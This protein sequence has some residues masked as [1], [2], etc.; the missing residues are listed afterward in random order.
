MGRQATWTEP[1][2]LGAAMGVFRRK[3]FAQTTVRDLQEATGLHPGSLYKAYGSKDRLFAAAMRAYNEQVVEARI[4]R[5]LLREDDP[6]AGIRSFFTSTFEKR[7][8]PD[9]GCL[10]TNTAIEGFGLD[11]GARDEVSTG[12]D[13]IERGLT[14][15]LR[16]AQAI[17]QLPASAPLARLA[18]RLLTLYQGLLV[19]VRSGAPRPKLRAIAADVVE[20]LALTPEK[21][22]KR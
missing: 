3:G 22:R 19:L 11:P 12:L 2:L 14:G 13:L 18:A 21:G 16:R 17:G 15:A 8:W 1:D 10:V 7:A 6:L 5:H 20:S 9:P 4:A